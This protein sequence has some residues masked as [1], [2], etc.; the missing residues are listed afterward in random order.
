MHTGPDELEV[1]TP[2]VA[3]VPAAKAYCQEIFGLPDGPPGQRRTHDGGGDGGPHTVAPAVTP[4]RS[5]PTVRPGPARARPG[6]PCPTR[7]RPGSGPSQLTLTAVQEAAT[8]LYSA[9]FAPYRS[10]AALRVAARAPA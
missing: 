5:A 8:A 10:D 3:D 6:R 2:F 4:G 9:L 1:I 7:A